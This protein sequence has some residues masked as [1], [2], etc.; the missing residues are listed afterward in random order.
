MVE[1]IIVNEVNIIVNENI[2]VNDFFRSSRPEKTNVA[3]SHSSVD[4][5]VEYL[6]LSVFNFK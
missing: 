5:S 3:C 1:N 4:L 2:I 6:H